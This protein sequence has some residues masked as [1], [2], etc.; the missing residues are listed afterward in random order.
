M[1]DN[2]KNT[3]FIIASYSF[4]A[5]GNALNIDSQDVAQKLKNKRLAWAHLDGNDENSKIWLEKNVPY[6]DHLIIEALFAHETRPRII[7]FEDGMLVILRGANRKNG[8]K[9][10][11]MSSIRLWIDESRIISVQRKV[12][13]PIV[14]LMNF[15]ESGTKK[16]RNAG[17]FIFNLAN[18]TLNSV[19]NAID[20]FDQKIDEVEKKINS[21]NKVNN[22]ILREILSDVRKKTAMYKRYM[23]P[24]KDV[25]S[26]LQTSHYKW[27]DDLSIRHLQENFNHICHMIEELGEIKER[28][29]I[30]YQDLSN[31]NA[32]KINKSMFN[33]TLIA[34][35]FLPLGFV[36]SLFGMNV[37]G[38][39]L[40]NDSSG[41]F[42]ISY[43]MAVI[44]GA[45]Y[46][47]IR[48]RSDN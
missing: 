27:I 23:I 15:I 31:L 44:F 36:A 47:M 4:D 16:I 6:L 39:P 2:S 5:N 13:T 37:G 9:E 3:N 33:I 11:E 7:E 34:S 18:E 26:H 1:K 35:I 21:R 38:V 19:D 10:S 28:S 12:F 43:F 17:E 20:E 45:L 42:I 22:Y 32:D 30:I 41:F 25:L 29:K 40:V 24:Q 14:E 48:S 46:L 8:K